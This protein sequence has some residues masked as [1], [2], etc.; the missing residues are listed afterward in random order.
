MSAVL[1]VHLLLA[2]LVDILHCKNLH[3]TCRYVC[4]DSAMKILQWCI[5][6]TKIQRDTN[7]YLHWLT[8]CTQHLVS[9][10]GTT[11]FTRRRSWSF[12][13]YWKHFV[14]RLNGVHAF[15]YNSAGCEPIW[16]KFGALWV[17]C[18]WLWQILGAIRAEAR[19][20]ERAE[21]LFFFVR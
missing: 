14:A 4:V 11:I 3:R 8:F 7:K 15:G 13:E 6:V 1:T 12:A 18:R 19:A 10:K 16:M 17:H 2:L 5:S 9:Q 20:R 21:I